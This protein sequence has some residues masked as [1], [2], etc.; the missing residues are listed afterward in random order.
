[1]SWNFVRASVLFQ[2]WN[3]EAFA[4]CPKL[5]HCTIYGP[6]R[7]TWNVNVYVNYTSEI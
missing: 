2:W 4:E 5:D 7:N 6:R 3:G 1:M